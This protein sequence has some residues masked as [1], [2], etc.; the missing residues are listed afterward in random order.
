MIKLYFKNA[1]WKL[2]AFYVMIIMIISVGFSLSI[3]KIG[4]NEINKGLGRQAKIIRDMPMADLFSEKLKVI[5]Q[6]RLDQIAESNRRLRNN[7][8][9][10][11]ILIL[12]LSTIASYFWAKRMMQPIE[13]SMERQ[14]QFTADASHELR[15]PLTAMKTEIEVALRDKNVDLNDTKKILSSN[16]E[17]I[18]KLESLSTSLLRLARN[19]H[20]R[21]NNQL[22]NLSEIIV[23]AYS[24][25]EKIAQKKQIEFH[26][27]ILPVEIIGDEENLIELFV[28]LLHN[29]VKYSPEKSVIKL[30]MKTEKGRILIEIIDQGIGIEKEDLPHIF[31]RFYRTDKARTSTKEGGY[32][33]GL[34]IAKTIIENHQGSIQVESTPGKGSTFKVSLLTM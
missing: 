24:R 17:E 13:E 9:S 25:V 3:Y 31:D 21:R 32:G 27:Q 16:L 11:N 29:A 33:L 30:K 18:G 28:I 23:S 20:G 7:L 4:T 1:Y 14:N 22:V 19:E 15:T 26:N 34:A 10:F 6:A 2:T 5:E 8:I 12:L